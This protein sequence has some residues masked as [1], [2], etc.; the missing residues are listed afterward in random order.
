MF[1]LL[2]ENAVQQSAEAS[3]LQQV[4]QLLAA[5]ASLTHTSLMLRFMFFTFST[6]KLEAFELI[7]VVIV[8][9][10]RPDTTA[11]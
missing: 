8:S 5:C 2:M 9:T 1:M 11:V 10:P 3:Q 7:P 4:L 6:Q